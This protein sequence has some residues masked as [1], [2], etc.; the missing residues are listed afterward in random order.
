MYRQIREYVESLFANA[1]PSAKMTDLKEEIITNLNDKYTDLISN[2]MGEEQAYNRVIAGIGDI[3]ELI[4][5]QGSSVDYAEVERQNKRSAFLTALAIGRYVFSLIPVLILDSFGFLEDIGAALMFLIVGVATGLI[6]YANSVRPKRGMLADEAQKKRA[7]TMSLAVSMY[8]FAIIPPVLISSRFRGLDN[9]SAI[10]M[11]L[12]AGIAT[13]ILIY[14]VMSKPKYVKTDDTIVEEFKQWQYEQKNVHTTC[15]TIQTIIWIL[16]VV[17]YIAINFLLGAWAV[18]WLL[19][20]IA[21]VINKIIRLCF[22]LA[23]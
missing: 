1:P 4:S 23:E 11:F 10:L 12:I 6:I 13:V 22:E 2:G 14:S 17:L 5:S 16:T 3:D 7:R 15:H 20:V 19:F 8:I 18:S 9:L 21:A